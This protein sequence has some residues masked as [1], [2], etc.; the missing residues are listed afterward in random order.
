MIQEQVHKK[1]IESCEKVSEWFSLQNKSK[2]FPI[3]SSFDVRDSGF[4]IAPVDANLFPAGFNN[5]CNVDRENAPEI[6]KKYLKE[7]YD[8]EVKNIA[9]ITEEH[10]NNSYYWE[11]VY[12][13]SQILSNAGLKVKICLPRAITSPLEIQSASGHK[14]TVYGFSEEERRSTDLIVCNN[15]FS[16]NY[17]EWDD[18]AKTPMN[19]P[20][21]LGWYQRRKFSFFSE[22]NQLTHDFAEMLGIDPFMLQ[23]KTELI[24][25]FDVSD[26]DRMEALAVKVDE[27]ILDL[28]EKYKK[29]NITDKPFCFLKNNT[30]TY[31]LAVVQVH[32]G[33]DILDWNNK[34]RKKMKAA[35][36]G[37]DVTELII[38]EGIATRFRDE[39]GSTAEP[40]I[41]LVGDEC[42]GGFLRTH[43][44]KGIDENLNSPGAVFKRLCMSDLKVDMPDCPMENVY[45]WI[46]RLGALALAREIEKSKIVF[47]GYRV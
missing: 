35:K 9:L 21:E 27:F 33:Q 19:P 37:R 39:D 44:S 46:S 24:S 18:S 38:Q 3:Y 4:K 42:V 12:A 10:T 43:K 26:S 29:H 31:G 45:G 40:C 47:R 23:V 34:D 5:I 36:G 32:S 1:I 7:H 2:V 20:R 11:N 30:G 41:Y 16:Q 8:I 15:D 28:N 6:V 25:E 14:I 13:L 22:Y 17:E